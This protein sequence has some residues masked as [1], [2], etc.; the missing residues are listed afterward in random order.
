[1]LIFAGILLGVI[2]AW[3][4]IS[5][6]RHSPGLLKFMTS[7]KKLPLPMLFSI[8]LSI[9]LGMAFGAAG[10][11]VLLAGISST[12]MTQPF[13]WWHRAETQAMRQKK[14]DPMKRMFKQQEKISQTISAPARS[15]SYMRRTWAKK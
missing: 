4:E 11:T 15:A 5:L 3:F 9:F 13:Y 2:S 1:M 10:L 12:C 6:V 8:I 7:F 14:L